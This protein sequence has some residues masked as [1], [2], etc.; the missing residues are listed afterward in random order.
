MIAVLAGTREQFEQFVRDREIPRTE[1]RCISTERD[2]QGG[3]FTEFH[4]VGTWM[5]L[6][7]SLVDLWQHC[8]RHR[9]KW[10]P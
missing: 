1:A 2:L 9:V 7:Q 5:Y 4:E 3:R 10:R 6:D 8:K